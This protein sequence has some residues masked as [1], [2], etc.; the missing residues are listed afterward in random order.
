MGCPY[1]AAVRATLVVVED[2]P[3]ARTSV[4]AILRAA[5]YDVVATA[6]S[7]ADA[8]TAVRAH[9]PQALVTDLN[10]GPGPTGL[11]L[12]VA[13]RRLLP[14]IG[15][16][17]LSGYADPRLVGAGLP[18]M[19]RGGQ[20]VV[21]DDV[22]EPDVLRAAVERALAGDPDPRPPLRGP[23]TRSQVDLLRMI[24]ASM[25]NA[26]IATERGVSVKA[27]EAA[28]HRLAHRLHI[29]GETNVRVALA[30]EYGRLSGG[31]GRT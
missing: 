19:P 2:E 9:L 11:D 15:I 17:V 23:L 25:T 1:T 24:A 5:S 29:P 3:F 20:Y 4:T 8:M 12:A 13:V 18:E 6:P 28:V 22:A 10:L 26:Q 30:R 27:V 21:K 14:R 31:A 7:A 16:V